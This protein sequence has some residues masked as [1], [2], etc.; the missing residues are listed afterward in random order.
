MKKSVVIVSIWLVMSGCRPSEERLVTS[1]AATAGPCVVLRVT[2]MVCE[3]CEATVRD[4]AEAV[5][6]VES[7]VVDAN[8]GTAR[9]CVR[10]GVEITPEFVSKLI[11]AIEEN[12]SHKATVV[13]PLDRAP[14]R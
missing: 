4:A 10:A 14:G 9:V 3:G 13:E 1:T 5:P 2:N 8:A 11:A 7:A 12:P 6:G